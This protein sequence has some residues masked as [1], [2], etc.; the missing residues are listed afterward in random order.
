MLLRQYHVFTP[1]KSNSRG[2]WLTRRVRRLD[3]N[4]IEIWIDTLLIY[5]SAIN[6]SELVFLDEKGYP[7]S[8]SKSLTERFYSKHFSFSGYLKDFIK[9]HL[10]LKI[11]INR[12]KVVL[13]CLLNISF[14]FAAVKA[15]CPKYYNFTKTLKPS[16]D[17]KSF[18]FL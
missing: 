13:D 4:R 17:L 10:S 7:F 14:V 12:H 15:L 11:T 3:M 1:W 8:Y 18:D 2:A 5:Y 6:L 16:E 9:T